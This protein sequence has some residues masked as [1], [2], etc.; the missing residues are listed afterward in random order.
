MN[1]ITGMKT[2]VLE[3]KHHRLVPKASITQTKLYSECG[4][5]KMI[6]TAD[7]TDAL[8]GM[9]PRARDSCGVGRAAAESPPVRAR[10]LDRWDTCSAPS[11]TTLY[12]ETHTHTQSVSL[13]QTQ[14]HIRRS[15]DALTSL[16]KLWRH[17]STHISSV[18]MSSW[19]MIHGSSMFS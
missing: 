3:I 18:L 7:R 2:C 10:V 14:T 17:S 12:T 16:W 13:H 8:S 9:R 15:E 11:A 1:F 6:Q 19:Q 4:L 5:I